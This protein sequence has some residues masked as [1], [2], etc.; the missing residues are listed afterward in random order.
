[1]KDFKA[2]VLDTEGIV[3]QLRLT[4]GVEIAVFAYQLTKKS[5]KFSL[6]AKNYADVNVI[7]TGFGGGGHVKAAG[8]EAT[9]V[10]SEILAQVLE[11]AKKQL[12]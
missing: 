11:E 9:G 5:Y 12:K 7:A 3:E 4:E 1:M 10:Y 8:F 6:R 2:N